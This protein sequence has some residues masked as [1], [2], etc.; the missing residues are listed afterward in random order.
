MSFHSLN[1]VEQFYSAIMLLD[2]IYKCVLV[3]DFVII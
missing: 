3:S 2:V 1:V